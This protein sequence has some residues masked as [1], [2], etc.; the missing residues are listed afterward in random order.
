MK[1]KWGVDGM[2]QCMIKNF[3][4]PLLCDEITFSF[5][6]TISEIPTKTEADP[7]F[8]AED[9]LFMF[10]LGEEGK[11]SADSFY[12]NKLTLALNKNGV[13]FYGYSPDFGRKLNIIRV[14]N[15]DTFF[16]G[17]YQFALTFTKERVYVYL[18]G[19]LVNAYG[20]ARDVIS[21]YGL[22][23]RNGVEIEF[24]DYGY[25]IQ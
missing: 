2:Q 15:E 12:Q 22:F 4:N 3:Q 25:Q 11:F 6:L 10:T 19:E 1:K 24:D 14:K 5:R 17:S 18:N 7:R 16:T 23:V 20:N 13:S 21:G 8:F 9:E